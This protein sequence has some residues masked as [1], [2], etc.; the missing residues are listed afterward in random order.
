MKSRC[1]SLFFLSEAPVSC[2]LIGE[3]N[4]PAGVNVSV[5]VCLSL[6]AL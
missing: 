2:R 5:N 6:S 3:C 4:L 1:K